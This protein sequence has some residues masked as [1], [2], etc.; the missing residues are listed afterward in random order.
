MILRRLLL[1]GACLIACFAS[2]GAPRAQ[3]R[4]VNVFNWNDYIDPAVVERFTRETGIRVR[5][6]VFDSL[7][8]LE[9]RLS[10]GRSG[11]DVIVP[12]SEPTFSRLARIGALL[13]LD[14]AQIPNL[15]NLDPALMR[16]V[17]SSD[18]G[19]RFGALYLWGTIGLGVNEARVRAL[20]P[21]APMDSLALL[22]D[23]R[24]ASRVARCGITMMDSA[25][26]VIPTVLRYLG[27][28][29]NSTSN[30]DL[31]AV[32]QTLMAIRPHIRNFSTGGVIEAL[33]S[34]QTCLAFAYSGDVIQASGRAAEAKQ[35][36]EVRYVAGKEG[37]Q[38]W[39]DLLAIPADA[40]N[41]ANA[42]AFINFLLQPDVMAAITTQVG[43]PNGIPASQA[44]VAPE[45][46]DDPAVFPDAAMRA[47]FFTIGPVPQAAE[48]ARNRMW[49][50]F[51]A[52][53]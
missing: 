51:K 1:L 9:G 7:E 31:R 24:H 16:Q 37:A 39:F 12:T 23:R 2:S 19:N 44:L 36:V 53:R 6:D 42:H 18:P 32:E 25:T 30:D 29:P 17:A 46:A 13:P 4:V 11:Y 38:L 49:A 3:E 20:A 52:G 15:A 50:R 5:Y 8:T 22:F 21:D 35:G 43:Y 47:R 26:D 33:A 45:I 27:K 28:D 34:G 40:P 10:A 41:P 48:R 14:R